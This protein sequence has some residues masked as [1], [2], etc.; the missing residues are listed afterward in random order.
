MTSLAVSQQ[1]PQ[2]PQE[3][4]VAVATAAVVVVA[5]AVFAVVVERMLVVPS[6]GVGVWSAARARLANEITERAIKLFISTPVVVV[7]NHSATKSS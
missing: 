7:P 1:T 2:S 3:A 5:V 4:V 6:A